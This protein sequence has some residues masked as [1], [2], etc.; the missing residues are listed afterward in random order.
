MGESLDSDRGLSGL[1]IDLNL[2]L[3]F[4]FYLRNFIYSGWKRKPPKYF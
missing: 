2:I 3:C 4:I 1:K